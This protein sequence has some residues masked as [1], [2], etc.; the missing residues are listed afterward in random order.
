MIITDTLRLGRFLGVFTIFSQKVK[1]K[2][3]RSEYNPAS[4]IQLAKSKNLTRAQR[5]YS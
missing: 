2:N 1:P 5:D 3:N 4:K